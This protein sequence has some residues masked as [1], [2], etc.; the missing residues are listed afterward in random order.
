MS[1]Y[2]TYCTA[3]N[4]KGLV[5]IIYFIWCG[6][7]VEFDLTPLCCWCAC[8]GGV[9][10]Q[11]HFHR[12]LFHITVL[13]PNCPLKWEVPNWPRCQIVYDSSLGI[14]GN[15][16]IISSCSNRSN[17]GV[18]KNRCFQNPHIT[19]NGVESESYPCQDFGLDHQMCYVYKVPQK[20]I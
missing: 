7:K 6:E 2:H 16:I 13:F 17:Q 14:K 15:I 3:L 19:W 12:Y 5:E 20:T 1:N 9:Q 10:C 18:Q 8:L 11:T 4:K